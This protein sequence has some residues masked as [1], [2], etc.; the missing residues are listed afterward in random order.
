MLTNDSFGFLGCEVEE[1]ETST[2]QACI[3]P[4][5]FNQISFN[6]CTTMFDEKHKPWCA[7]KVDVKGKGRADEGFWGYCQEICPQ[8][9]I[10]TSKKLVFESKIIILG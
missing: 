3:F 10:G 1:L 7:T 4:F 5:E 9:L 6:G 8:D 2:K